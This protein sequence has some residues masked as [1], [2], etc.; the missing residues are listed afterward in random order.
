MCLGLFDWFFFSIW[1]FFLGF[2]TSC[3]FQ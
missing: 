1:F 3:D 2:I